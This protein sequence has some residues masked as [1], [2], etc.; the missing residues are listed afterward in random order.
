MCTCWKAVQLVNKILYLSTCFYPCVNIEP[1]LRGGVGGNHCSHMEHV[2]TLQRAPEVRIKSGSL[3]LW[4][5][6]WEHKFLGIYMIKFQRWCIALNFEYGSP[7]YSKL[8]KVTTN[9]MLSL[10]AVVCN[11][12]HYSINQVYIQYF[13]VKCNVFKVNITVT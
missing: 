11:Y 9:I 5:W 1:T 3:A 10:H 4:F 13:N 2:Q 6:T 7:H 12:M 8:F